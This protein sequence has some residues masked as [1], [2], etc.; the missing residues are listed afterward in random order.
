MPT[1]SRQ[2]QKLSHNIDC[3]KKKTPGWYNYIIYHHHNFQQY[4]KVFMW[5]KSGKEER[6]KTL[7]WTAMYLPLVQSN[8]CIA[9]YWENTKMGMQLTSNIAT[10]YYSL[11]F[12][13]WLLLIPYSFKTINSLLLWWFHAMLNVK[14]IYAHI[15]TDMYIPK[16]HS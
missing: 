9:I 13:H 1:L 2:C 11:A 15:H 16:P 4:A 5:Y 7:V 12:S 8:Y 14:P 3:R 10:R 6:H